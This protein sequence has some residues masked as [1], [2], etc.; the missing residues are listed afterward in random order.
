VWFRRRIH[1]DEKC[2][3]DSIVGGH[4]Q[5]I[6]VCPEPAADQTARPRNLGPG[7]AGAAVALP[8]II[9]TADHADWNYLPPG[10]GVKFSVKCAGWPR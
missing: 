10:E 1:A 4:P 3:L 5:L 2:V 9:V 7:A 8:P 6:W